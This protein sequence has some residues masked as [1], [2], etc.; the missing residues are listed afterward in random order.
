[1]DKPDRFIPEEQN[2]VST[3]LTGPES[4]ALRRRLQRRKISGSA[5]F[6][7]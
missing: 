6:L 7:R 1:M 4:G 5:L 2:L 3:S